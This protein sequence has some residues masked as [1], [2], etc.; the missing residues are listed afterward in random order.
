MKNYNWLP[1]YSLLILMFFW[2][3]SLLAQEEAGPIFSEDAWNMEELN[4]EQMVRL[5]ALLQNHSMEDIIPIK[6]NPLE[7]VQVQ[8]RVALDIP[9]DECETGICQSYRM[10]YVGPGNYFWYGRIIDNEEL[11]EC[12]S[13]SLYLMA[14]EGEYYGELQMDLQRYNIV[15]LSGE[16][17]VL[18]RLSEDAAG[19]C[20]LP[21]QEY[22][23]G[24]GG[25]MSEEELPEFA[26]DRTGNCDIRILFVYT[27]ATFNALGG[28]VTPN[29]DFR[30]NYANQILANSGISSSQL[31]FESA[32]F[33]TININET[34]G[35]MGN[36]LSTFAGHPDIRPFTAGSIN[37]NSLLWI[38]DAD[39][40]V[41]TIDGSALSDPLNDAEGIAF[42]GPN[43]ALPVTVIQGDA[44]SQSFAHEIGHLL[45]AAHEPCIADDPGTNC[46]DTPGNGTQQCFDTQASFNHGHTWT[47]VRRRWICPDI[48]TPRKTIMYSRSSPDRIDYISNPNVSFNNN[49]TGIANERDNARILRDN[50]CTVA[51]FRPDPNNFYVSINGPSTV[52][53]YD[54]A[55]L[56]VTPFNAPGPYNYQWFID[57]STTPASTTNSLSVDALN[58][59]AGDVINVR[60]D[61]TA[62][63]NGNLFDQD[64][65]QITVIDPPNGEIAC[66][67]SEAVTQ[68]DV[69]TSFEIIPNPFR[70]STQVNFTLETAQNISLRLFDS[71]GKMIHI[72]ES[73]YL[74]EGQHFYQIDQSM[75]PAAG[76]YFLQFAGANQSFS[77]RL[78]VY[79]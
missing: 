41:L 69:V 65:L 77:R 8:G 46:C 52:C 22:G 55:Y 26:I 28:N 11:C 5:E 53:V 25:M 31:R 12:F 66:M 19:H 44:S 59:S 64:F 9:E 32:G 21:E 54:F 57:M 33:A 14:R 37:G 63:P 39:L 7:D 76:I 34:G 75:V 56:N 38:N 61:V 50:A 13:G 6:I 42:L 62:G 2:S 1:I 16:R 48:E 70:E 20:Q 4:D 30:I 27:N 51:N 43:Q 36:L 23:G 71:T 29:I 15:D 45:G 47:E 74:G 10:D 72:L 18:V 78:V 58:Y 67:Q 35:T 40:A 60:V 73:T 17:R 24:E 3:N 49:D 68:P 79:K